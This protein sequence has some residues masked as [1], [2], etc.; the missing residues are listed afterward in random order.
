M[1][2]D[3]PHPE[4]QQL[5]QQLESLDVFPLRQHGPSAARDLLRNF[6]ASHEEPAMADVT[7]RAV[8][9][10][11]SRVGEDRDEVPVRVYTPEGEGPFP[12]TVF[13]HGGGFVIGDLE[14][15]D[16]LC[17]HVAADTGCVVVAVDYR[18]APEHP[19]P[20]ALEDAYAATEWVAEN[21][22][23]VEGDGQLAVMGD[24]AGGNLAAAVTLLSRERDGPEIDYQ[25]LVYPAVDPRED[26]PSWE[27]NKEGY[28]LVVEDM[29][30]F[31]GCYFG[32]DIHEVN[33]YAFPLTADSHADL[34][35][36]TVLTAGFDPL[37]DE[38]IAYA[39]TL[40]GAG[41]SVQHRNYDDMIHGF[42]TMLAPPA[43]LTVAHEAVAE[44]SADLRAAFR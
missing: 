36:A 25:V 18:L 32:S 8:P 4:A 17:R 41:V 37:R 7:Y 2:A 6:G 43:D 34:P 42:I 40:S 21:P 9:G 38:G 20:A 12:V 11:E 22:E 16:G 19:F 28:F 35:P 15:H 5:L 29:E 39:E 44:I 31:A 3:E 33:P 24:S 13:Y 30:W 1:R 10:Y 27:Q 26:R 23:E 14:T